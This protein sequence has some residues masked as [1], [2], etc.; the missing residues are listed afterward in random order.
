MNAS[1]TD[2]DVDVD[3]AIDAVTL[4]D[5]QLADRRTDELAKR[6][7]SKCFQASSLRKK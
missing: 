1:A 7:V 3:I 2:V 4:I 5:F 6:G